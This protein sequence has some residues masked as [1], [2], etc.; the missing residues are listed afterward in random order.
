MAFSPETW[1][2]LIGKIRKLQEEIDSLSNALHW[3]G[4]T[5][6]PIT[7]GQD[8]NPI[9]IDGRSITVYNGDVTAYGGAE[10]VY[11][12]SAWQQFGRDDSTYILKANLLQATGSATDNVMSQKASTD[13]FGEKR[14]SFTLSTTWTG[15][16]SPYTQVVSIT[17]ITLTATAKIELL[18]TATQINQLVSDGVSSLIA[19]N[20]NGT[21]VIY[22]IGAVPSVAMN[23][24]CIVSETI[25]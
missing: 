5:T 24:T 4:V 20:D 19:E 21:C 23:I 1:V 15:L 9:V 17:G 16:S 7:D 12:G 2:L 11:D 25:A 22:A 8:A 13:Y 10:F 3:L 18:L 6:T 14:A